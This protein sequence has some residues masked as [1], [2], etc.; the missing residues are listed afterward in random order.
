GEPPHGSTS[1]VAIVPRWPMVSYRPSSGKLLALPNQATRAAGN[2]ARLGPSGARSGVAQA[3]RYG[4]WRATTR[5]ARPVTLPGT[6][7]EP[8]PRLLAAR[9][10]PDMETRRASCSCGQ[11]T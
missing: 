4:L 5:S 6:R 2:E 9:Y 8:R 7:T 1:L 11:L 10:R 3:S